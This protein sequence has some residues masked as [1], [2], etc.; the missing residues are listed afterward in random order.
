MRTRRVA[1]IRSAPIDLIQRPVSRRPRRGL[2]AV[3]AA[4][5]A[6]AVLLMA[7]VVVIPT[8]RNIEFSLYKWDGIGPSRFIG[9]QNY[10]VA[11]STPRVWT[12]FFN[13]VTF[14]LFFTLGS[15][16]VGYAL[17]SAIYLG[18]RGGHVF[19]FFVLHSRHRPADD[20]GDPLAGHA[21]TRRTDLPTPC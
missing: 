19:R 15:V 7:L 3:A 18:V 5:I 6:P 2:L 13:T 20:D 17:A 10:L 8:L 16:V 9:I 14:A 11:L 12:A 1:W 4:F 21:A